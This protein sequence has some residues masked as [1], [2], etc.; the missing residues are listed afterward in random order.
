MSLILSFCVCLWTHLS[1]IILEKLLISLDLT[2]AKMKRMKRQ[3][4]CGKMIHQNEKNKSHLQYLKMYYYIYWCSHISILKGPCHWQN[5][6]MDWVRL[7][8]ISDENCLINLPHTTMTIE[9]KQTTKTQN[10]M[11]ITHKKEKR[12][13][14]KRNKAISENEYCQNDN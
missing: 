10:N 9:K 13:I 6:V 14:R 3:K 5:I 4:C 7:I 1:A 12:E 2:H 11:K 8:I